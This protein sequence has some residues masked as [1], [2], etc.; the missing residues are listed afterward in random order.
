H[1]EKG[2]KSVEKLE[3]ENKA[4][5]EQNTM[6]LN[7]HHRFSLR[8]TSWRK[9]IAE[10]KSGF[11]KI[12]TED[13]SDNKKRYCCYFQDIIIKTKKKIEEILR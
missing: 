10:V 9:A 7:I 12:L 1:A 11:E 4:L 8:E 13:C 3:A 6:L 5:G 2:F